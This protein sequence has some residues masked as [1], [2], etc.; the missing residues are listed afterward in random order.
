[1]VAA[2]AVLTAVR[3]V[4]SHLAAAARSSGA[5]YTCSNARSC[6]AVVAVVRLER[7]VVF[8]RAAT[9][10]SPP[11]TPRSPLAIYARARETLLLL[12]FEACGGNC[13][14]LSAATCVAA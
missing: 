10:S 8:T 13:V 7:N 5:C 4:N 1:M 2:A 12:L 11:T 9:S 3:V 6:K 14:M